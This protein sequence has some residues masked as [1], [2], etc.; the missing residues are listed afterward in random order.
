MFGVVPSNV[1]LCLT[2]E[3]SF[4]FFQEVD[5]KEVSIKKNDVRGFQHNE[6]LFLTY[7]LGK[8]HVAIWV[9]ERGRAMFHP[10]NIFSAAERG[11]D[12]VGVIMG[13]AAGCTLSITDLGCHPHIVLILEPHPSWPELTCW[14]AWQIALTD[15]KS[16]LGQ[17]IIGRVCSTLLGHRLAG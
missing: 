6:K 9:W 3:I 14:P 5:N 10:R 1:F 7:L 16:C 4:D 17:S 12:S 15:A 11:L 13:R 8:P 2:E